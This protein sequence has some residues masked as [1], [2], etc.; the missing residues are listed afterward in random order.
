[1]Y[2]VNENMCSPAILNS[3]GGDLLETGGSRLLSV[4]R[5]N[6]SKQNVYSLV[7]KISL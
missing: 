5:F 4:E 1:M 6:H 3:L 7:I 2:V